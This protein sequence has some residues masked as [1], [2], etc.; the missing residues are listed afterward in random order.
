MK[1]NRVDRQTVRQ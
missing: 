1:N